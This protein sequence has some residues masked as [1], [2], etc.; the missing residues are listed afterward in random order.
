MENVNL[1]VCYLYDRFCRENYVKLFLD[2]D[3]KPIYLKESK[4]EVM[5]LESGATNYMYSTRT[6][7]RNLGLSPDLITLYSVLPNAFVP[8]LPFLESYIVNNGDNENSEA[9]RGSQ[10]LIHYSQRKYL[11]WT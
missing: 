3:S 1:R 2:D 10:F 6:T 11:Y 7:K 8:R 9:L 4:T 5:Y